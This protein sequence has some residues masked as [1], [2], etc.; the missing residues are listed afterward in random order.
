MIISGTGHR[1]Q[2]L[3]GFSIVRNKIFNYVCKTAEEI[4]IKE[5]PTK[6]ITGMALGWDTWLAQIAYKLRIPFIA[7]VPFVGQES[8][9]PA[10][11]KST[12][13]KLLN[14]ASEVVIVSEGLYSPEKMQ[15]RNEWM[16][17]HSDKVLAVWDGTNGGTGNCVKYAASIGKEIIRINPQ[18]A[19]V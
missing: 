17:N 13:A 18:Q 5:N 8:I 12:Y 4:L 10:E 3:G 19:Y 9:W 15:R 6:I 16:V 14:L 7:A 2:K 1:P 11:S